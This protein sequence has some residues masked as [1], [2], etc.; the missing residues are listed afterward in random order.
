MNCLFN[1]VR[2][3]EAVRL[4]SIHVIPK[5]NEVSLDFYESHCRK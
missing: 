4:N 3:C 1:G 5:E 2:S